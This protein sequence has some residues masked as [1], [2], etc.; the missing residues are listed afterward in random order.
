V[1]ALAR[2]AS[3]SF[4]RKK[5]A[6]PSSI[7]GGG[8]VGHG[9]HR[10][11]SDRKLSALFG[12]ASSTSLVGHDHSSP[13]AERRASAKG[14]ADAAK[15]S[16]AGARQPMGSEALELRH[17][18]RVRD[19]GLVSVAYISSSGLVA[20]AAADGTANLY[21]LNGQRIGTFG[22][23]TEWDLNTA[24]TYAARTPMSPLPKF[25]RLAEEARARM[26]KASARR[27]W[28][29]AQHLLAPEN[30][31]NA[32]PA[33]TASS[34]PRTACGRAGRLSVCGGGGSGS[35][36]SKYRY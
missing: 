17:F 1:C 12:A 34:T 32:E 16:G 28:R 6:D 24:T 10:C 20:T 33:S 7:F 5:S 23:P 19:F 26:R 13:L 11:A 2:R 4:A 8:G 14:L 27:S 30:D 29:S 22:Q 35:G 36:R 18:W 15:G 31:Q 9:G 25:E 21:T 3:G